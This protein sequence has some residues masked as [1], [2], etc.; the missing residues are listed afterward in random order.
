MIYDFA[1]VGAG[2]S[3][4]NI[5]WKLDKSNASVLILEKSKSCG[6]RMATRRLNESKFDH[7][8]QF[9]K[10]TKTSEALIEFW[11]S[12]HILQRFPVSDFESY[13]GLGGMT[14]L[15]KE[16]SQNL[17]VKYNSKVTTLKNTAQGWRLVLD[18]GDSILSKK[19]ILSCPLPQS[20][21]LVKNSDIPFDPKLQ[22]IRYAK[23]IVSL[24]SLQQPL[25]E[26][27]TFVENFDSD[28]YSICSQKVK[29]LSIE[30]NYTIV[31]TEK[32]SEDHFNLSDD[33][34]KEKSIVLI[35]TK[36]GST[37]ISDFQIKKWRYC[38]PTSTWP[39]LFCQPHPD[40][41]LI[42]DAFGG[43]SLNGALMSSD[44]LA[45]ELISNTQV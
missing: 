41:Y 37:N 30:H 5:G 12:K 2:I 19:I 29:G 39:E 43:P 45:R 13:F 4:L 18:S 38:Q 44:G 33:E 23:S 21:E 36:F 11:A 40:I 7:G 27:L 31:M 15:T 10:R 16:I 42:G 28:I 34:I 22:D 25:K 17:N 20:L 8:A 1:I 26:H 24:I 32:W 35:K 14:R 9:I 6:G 3:G